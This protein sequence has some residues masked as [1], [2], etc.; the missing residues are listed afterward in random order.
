MGDMGHRGFTLVE[1][2]VALAVAGMLMAGLARL[3]VVQS[4]VYDGHGTTTRA[5]QQLRLVLDQLAREAGVAGFDPRGT[6][7]AGLTHASPDSLG[8]TA[9]LDADGLLEAE[10]SEGSERVLYTFDATRGELV[11]R[12]AGEEAVLL[13]ADSVVFGYLDRQ[14][15]TA[16]DPR[17]AV[18]FRILVHAGDAAGRHLLARVVAPNLLHAAP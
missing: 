14:G 7:G 3:L 8:W 16:A 9:D 10:G 5:A 15:R 12:A 11:R 2:V 18:Q 1:L 17:R 13:A 6:A 4:R